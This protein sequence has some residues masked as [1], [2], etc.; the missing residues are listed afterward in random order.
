M[1]VACLLCKF[2]CVFR[3]TAYEGIVWIVVCSL[4]F[5]LIHWIFLKTV[6]ISHTNILFYVLKFILIHEKCIY[7]YIYIYIYSYF[8]GMSFRI[9]RFVSCASHLTYS[10]W[11]AYAFSNLF[12]LS[13][14][15]TVVHRTYGFCERFIVVVVNCWYSWEILRFVS[16][17]FF[18]LSNSLVIFWFVC[19]RC[20]GI[21][22]GRKKT[23]IPLDSNLIFVVYDY[24]LE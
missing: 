23:R 20:K 4:H 11:V 24:S 15:L 18:F 2:Y 14:R 22:D 19:R 13:D 17:S 3:N 1:T 5:Q 12:L 7:I 9:P 10:Q 21:K 6:E 8:S 16:D